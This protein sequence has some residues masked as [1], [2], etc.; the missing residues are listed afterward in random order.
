MSLYCKCKKSMMSLAWCLNK[1]L[2]MRLTEWRTEYFID[3][4]DYQQGKII[5]KTLGTWGEESR[6]AFLA[7]AVR[8]TPNPSLPHP[9][10]KQEMGLVLPPPL[11]PCMGPYGPRPPPVAQPTYLVPASALAY[12]LL[13]LLIPHDD[14]THSPTTTTQKKSTI[15]VFD[16][17]ELT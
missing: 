9:C 1:A 3:L 12:A 13:P 14:Q 17:V 11:P 7:Q 10:S 6:K 5:V 15:S 8:L 4:R 2:Q 16:T